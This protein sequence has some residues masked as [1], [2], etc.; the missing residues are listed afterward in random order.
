MK[1]NGLSY[2]SNSTLFD[3]LLTGFKKLS[4]QGDFFY[5][6]ESRSLFLGR[7]NRLEPLPIP[8]GE[9]GSFFMAGKTRKASRLYQ[10]PSTAISYAEEFYRAVT[11]EQGFINFSNVKEKLAN[12]GLAPEAGIGRSGFKFKYE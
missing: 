11:E 2:N 8:R 1:K 12:M 9:T 7:N 5:N 3:N 4:T 6:S 10:D